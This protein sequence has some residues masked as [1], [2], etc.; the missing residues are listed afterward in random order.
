[1]EKIKTIEEN[2]KN[3]LLTNHITYDLSGSALETI[4]EVEEKENIS[5]SIYNIK[6]GEEKI[7]INNKEEAKNIIKEIKNILNS[8]YPNVK[9]S[10]IVFQSVFISSNSRLQ[11]K[12]C[13]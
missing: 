4:F 2:I 11:I 10:W 3:I 9:I 8:T 12:V 7:N 5:L 13:E 1:M 6:N